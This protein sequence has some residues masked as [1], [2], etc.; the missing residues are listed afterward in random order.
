LG[1]LSPSSA[2]GTDPSAGWYGPADPDSTLRGQFTVECVEGSKSPWEEEL[3]QVQEQYLPMMPDGPNP[4][5]AYQFLSQAASRNRRR[6]PR[7]PVG[8]AKQM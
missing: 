7:Y 6:R 2:A 4:K 8:G 1:I 3:R 5:L